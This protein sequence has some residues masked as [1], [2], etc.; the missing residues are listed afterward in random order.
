MNHNAVHSWFV[1][2]A[3]VSEIQAR[4]KLHL[5]MLFFGFAIKDITM[6]TNK[7]AGSGCIKVNSAKWF[8]FI[9]LVVLR[10]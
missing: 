4:V 10:R 3:Q 1:I 8:H 2:Q 5:K 7:L 6:I 9:Q